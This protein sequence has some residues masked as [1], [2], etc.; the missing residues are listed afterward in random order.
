MRSSRTDHLHSEVMELK[1]LVMVASVDTAI[2]LL[3]GQTLMD[4][5][6]MVATATLLHPQLQAES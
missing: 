3:I 4:L 1:A 2:V 5:E 6:V